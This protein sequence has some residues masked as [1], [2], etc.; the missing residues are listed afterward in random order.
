MNYSGKAED[1]EGE[2][3]SIT[4]GLFNVDI[5][6]DIMVGAFIMDGED[7]DT[8]RNF[9]RTGLQFQADVLQDLRVQGLFIAATDDRDSTFPHPVTGIL[10][11]HIQWPGFHNLAERLLIA[12]LI[13]FQGRYAATNVGTVDPP[14]FLRNRRRGKFL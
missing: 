11:S 8:N 6:D 10:H 4:S 13:H 7:K 2:N 3:A 12:G 9:N 5:T 1:A 14:R